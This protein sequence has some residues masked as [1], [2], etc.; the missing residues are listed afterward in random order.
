MHVASKQA[1]RAQLKHVALFKQQ[2]QQHEKKPDAIKK[3][4][5]A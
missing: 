4:L 5:Y 3:E 2:Q 1:K